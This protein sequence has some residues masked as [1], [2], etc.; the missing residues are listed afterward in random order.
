MS[1]KKASIFLIGCILVLFLTIPMFL[2]KKYPSALNNLSNDKS[3]KI[4]SPGGYNFTR[5]TPYNINMLDPVDSYSVSSDEVIRQ[6]AET[7]WF[8]NWTD[9]ALPR[10][11]MLAEGETWKNS[12][13]LEITLQQGVTFHDGTQFNASA[14]D[15][16]IN[17]MMYLF[18]H[19]GAL[20]SFEH[21]GTPHELF[22]LPNG[23]AI[24]AGFEV[25]GTYTG[26]IHLAHPF[27]SLMDLFCAIPASIISPTAHA[28]NS[29]SFINPY[30]GDLIGT[31]PY[32][33]DHFIADAEI[34][35]SRWDN[36]WGGP[37]PH[38]GNVVHF[39]KMF[40]EI[41]GDSTSRHDAMLNGDV[42]YLSGVEAELVDTFKAHPNIILHE[43]TIPDVDIGYLVF[44]NKQINKTWRKA[45]SYAYNYNYIIKDYHQDT[46]FR[47]YGPVSQGFGE[48]YNSSIES[49]APY[50]SKTIA[51]MILS[52]NDP[53]PNPV[54][55]IPEAIGRDPLNDAEWGLGV[56][57]LISFNYSYNTNNQWR[58][59]LYPLLKT[60]YDDLS[61][62]ITDGGTSDWQWFFDRAYGYV[63]GGYDDLQ[64]FWTRWIADYLDPISMLQPLLSNASNWNSAQV[65]DPTLEQMFVDYLNETDYTTKV[66]MIYNMSKYLVSE[67]YPYI[68]G[69]HNLVQTC[70]SKILDD[71]PYDINRYTF[72][73]YPIKPSDYLYVSSPDDF[74]VL[75]GEIGNNI[76]W[77]LVGG[78]LTNPMYYVYQDG[79]LITNDTW[80]SSDSVAVNLD[81]LSIGTYNY[82]IEVTDG[83]KTV[84]DSV[85]VNVVPRLV[86]SHPSD[87]SYT[88]GATGNTISW[89]V[90]EGY[91]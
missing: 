43:S 88:E 65:N 59:D 31:G 62:D 9:P 30:T 17:R 8:Y 74:A 23:S 80:Q 60:W 22:E 35:F 69:D 40:F 54:P 83:S 52:G 87:I 71:V 32:M 3:I 66:E 16:N 37:I 26:I 2:V 51:R 84:E 25:T 50:Y 48:W 46:V 61:I 1:N 21:V 42:D 44:N 75:L 58:S 34:R 10:I 14:V 64:L 27:T 6:V 49:V 41:I 28:S 91:E 53:T 19:T 5:A 82:S 86:I 4:T 76:V 38:Q 57:E 89:V 90:S 7:L 81:G 73:A 68:Y 15:W 36:Y 29:Q 77:D 24:L 47:A 56:N 70:H 18:N 63:P 78:N 72:Y 55:G 67:L 20:A 12:T 39:E 13:A 85:M 79:T 33:Y 11:N 45:M